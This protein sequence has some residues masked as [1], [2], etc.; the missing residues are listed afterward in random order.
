[1]T[2]LEKRYFLSK[3][4]ADP[5]FISLE[6]EIFSAYRVH[7]GQFHFNF[8]V[9]LLP[10]YCQLVFYES[11]KTALFHWQT[12]SPYFNTEVYRIH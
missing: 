1:M 4:K 10:S 5:T 11:L 2:E 12:C 3:F 6:T 9:A 7:S 8:L